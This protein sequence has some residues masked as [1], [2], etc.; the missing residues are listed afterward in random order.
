MKIDEREA[1][2]RELDDEEAFYPHSDG[3]P[4]GESNSH[5]WSIVDLTQNVWDILLNR[6]EDFSV[7]SDMFWYWEK[8]NRSAVRAPDLMVLFGVP[9][10][11]D[12]LSYRAW[13]YDNIQPA[14]IIE[15]ASREQRRMLLGELKDDYERLGVREYFVFDWSEG[16]MPVP[17]VG[18]RLNAGRYEP[19]APNADGTLYSIE[20]QMNMRAE[21]YILRFIYPDTGRL[22]LTPKE[23]QKATAKELAEK[24]RELARRNSALAT[25][26]SQLAEKNAELEKLRKLLAD[27]GIDADKISP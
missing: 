22:L 23:R 11:F 3:K 20:L 21:G 5:W 8:G 16:Y 13:N 1:P 14:L 15:T 18:F 12:R 24:E 26:D 9:Y 10:V 4:L 2:L 25:K 27:S 17:L 6:E 7:H 19:I